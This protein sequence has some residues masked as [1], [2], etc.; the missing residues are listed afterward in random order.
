MPIDDICVIKEWVQYSVC[1]PFR[2]K[3]AWILLGMLSCSFC[4]TSAEML[5]HAFWRTSHSSSCDFGCFSNF[6]RSKWSQIASMIF[7]SGLCG[8]HSISSRTP[9]SSFLF[10]YL[11]NFFA[12]CLGSLSYWK[13]KRGPINRLPDCMAGWM[14]ICLYF[15]AFIIQSIPT[16]SPTPPAEIQSK[17]CIDPPPCF[18]VR[19]KQGSCNSSPFLLRTYWSRLLPKISNF[20]LSLHSTFFHWSE[21]QLLCSHAYFNRLVLFPF[22]KRGFL[23]VS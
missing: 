2:F 4:G 23:T 3:T 15:S 12:M 6:F 7:K 8:G 17:T 21:F 22:L 5:F 20:D 13:V 9:W 16:K 11:L 14:K 10:K 19:C 18:T 1:Q